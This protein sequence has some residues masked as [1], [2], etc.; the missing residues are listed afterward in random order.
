MSFLISIDLSVTNTAFLFSTFPL[1]V[2]LNNE[3]PLRE[4]ARDRAT[5]WCPT[6]S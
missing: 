6:I 1:V 5:S 2:F 4:V 3:I